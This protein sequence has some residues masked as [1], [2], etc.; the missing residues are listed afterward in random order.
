MNTPPAGDP[1]FSTELAG[2]ARE[3][4]AGRRALATR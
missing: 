2:M 1:A 4:A 3:L